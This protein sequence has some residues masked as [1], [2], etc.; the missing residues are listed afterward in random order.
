MADLVKGLTVVLERDI[1]DDD[2]QAIISAIQQIRGVASVTPHITT[3]EDYFV[4]RRTKLKIAERFTEVIKNE[5]L[6]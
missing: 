1:R 2:A 4:A 5:L 6:D 3:G